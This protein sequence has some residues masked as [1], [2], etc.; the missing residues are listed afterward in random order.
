MIPFSF[1]T[2]SGL[3]VFAAVIL[4]PLIW[5][6]LEAQTL[7]PR[8]ELF[9]DAVNVSMQLSPDGKWVSWLDR[10]RPV[11]Q[12][13]LKSTGAGAEIRSVET[14]G[15]V[16]SY[17]WDLKSRLLVQV[18][19]EQIIQLQLV[20]IGGEAKTL[21]E[22]ESPMQLL[23]LS[24]LRNEEALVRIN[25]ADSTKEG[26]YL[27]NLSTQS[28]KKLMSAAPYLLMSF[29]GNYELKAATVPNS[30][31][32]HDLLVFEGDS[33]RTLR[34]YPGDATYWLGHP[35]SNI[36]G[37]SFDGETLY[38]TDN[39]GRDKAALLSYSFTSHQE[40]ELA[41]SPDANLLWSSCSFDPATNRLTSIAALFSVGVRICLDPS[42]KA[43]YDYLLSLGM[44]EPTLSRFSADMS[45]WLIRFNSGGPVRFHLYEPA[46]KKVTHMISENPALDAYPFVK[47]SPFTVIT[48]DGLKL[49][50]QLFLPEGSDADGDHIPDKPLPLVMYM[51]GGP[52]IG[53]Q[54]NSWYANRCFQLMANRGYAVVNTE[55]RGATDYGTAFHEKSYGELGGE[56]QEDI[57]AIR[58]WLVDH[59]IADPDRVGLFGWSYG[60]YA[61]VLALGKKPNDYQCALAMYGVYNLRTFIDHPVW[62]NW[63]ADSTTE[64]G[65][66]R[67]VDHS[68]ITWVKDI[69]APIFLTHGALDQQAPASQTQELIAA[70]REYKKKF[71]CTWYPNEGHDYKDPQSWIGYWA[72]A[73]ELLHDEL[74]GRVEK[75][76]GDAKVGEYEW[77]EGKKVVN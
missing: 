55:F 70:L 54:Q 13:Q 72:Y 69:Q 21:L 35:A 37:L 65:R 67:I 33:V 9:A 43:H 12:V 42:V 4:L 30:L 59:Q 19:T 39:A 63:V 56:M 50:C 51:H 7:I 15:P 66:F 45:R 38:F 14:S 29:S 34:S 28:S 58:S 27:L 76:G 57:H 1:C 41:A 52:W 53:L 71:A 75:K 74:G 60:A 77:L 22:S 5:N 32:G 31:E 18:R 49:P 3:H 36:C 11:N 8:Q 23:P 20:T 25:S 68:P 2:R 44:G 10:S 48:H 16:T 46:T 62:V 24:P 6:P 61:A 26:I 47:R 64:I 40:K 73:E 17:Q